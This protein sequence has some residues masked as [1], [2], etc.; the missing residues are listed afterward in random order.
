MA[1]H[2]T[3]QLSQRSVATDGGLE[4]TIVEEPYAV[5]GL[6][7]GWRDLAVARGNPFVTPEFFDAWRSFTPDAVRPFVVTA[8]RGGVLA[9]VLP[10]SIRSGRFGTRV[11]LAGD[12][13]GDCFHPASSVEDEVAIA[14]AAGQ[15]LDERDWSSVE[16]RN[17]LVDSGWHEALTDEAGAAGARICLP[18]EDMPYLDFS[19]HDWDGYLASKSR[20]FRKGLWRSMRRLKE[21]GKVRFRLS[22]SERLDA[23]LRRLF[24]LHDRRWGEQS[25]FL[26]EPAIRFHTNFARSALD[27]GWLRLGCL[28]L[29]GTTIASTIGWRLGD[30]FNEYQRGYEPGLSRYGIGRLVM[31]EMMRTLN[32]EGAVIYDQLV[33]AEGYKLQIQDGIRNVETIRVGRPW[34]AGAATIRA[35]AVA[36]LAYEAAPEAL[37][38][39]VRKRRY[40]HLAE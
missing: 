36:R 29:D 18:R 31:G 26:N 4:I 7:D 34:R 1:V 21:Q 10:L 25:R 19:G 6:R 5:P 17:A 38:V 9:G 11:S 15:L 8:A 2:A 28:E 35:E 39:A 14:S 3:N 37:R 30:R 40:P 12:Q 13:F 24:E 33:G 22:D 32:E 23:D 16:L 27:R 20:N